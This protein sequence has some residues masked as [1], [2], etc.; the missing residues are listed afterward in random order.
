VQ[1]TVPLFLTLELTPH[2]LRHT[3]ANLAIS[4][5][6]NV[7]A[8][9]RMLGQASAA[10]TRDLY[11]NL[12]DEDLEALSTALNDAR[13]NSDVGRMWAK[14]FNPTHEVVQLPRK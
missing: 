12:F 11:A 7:K 6:G 13:A 5:G 10:M 14:K 9:Q 1:R 3:A 2:D 8:I 4:A